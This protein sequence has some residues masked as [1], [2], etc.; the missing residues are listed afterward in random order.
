MTEITEAIVC[1]TAALPWTNVAS[2]APRDSTCWRAVLLILCAMLGLS[3]ARETQAQLIADLSLKNTVDVP[4]PGVGEQ[5]TFMVTIVNAGPRSARSIV[6]RDRLPTGYTYVAS[7]TTRGAYNATN[8]RWNLGLAAGE[9]AVLN[10]VGSVKAQGNY[11]DVAEVLASGSGDPDSMPGNGNSDEDD[12]AQASIAPR[13]AQAPNVIVV[14]V[15]DLD[16]RSLD[17]LL[18]AGLMPNFQTTFVERGIEFTE[19]FVSTPL[20]CPSRATFLKG[21]Y[22]HNTGIVNNQLLYPGAGL[23]W[24]VSRFDDSVTLATRLQGLGYRTAHIGK[25]LNGYGSDPRLS[26]L[27]PA[28][29]PH[30]I[31]PGWTDWWGLVDFSTYC[32]Y[33]YTINHNATLTQILRPLGETENSAAYQT[34]VLADTAEEF[35]LD[36]KD[37]A[38]PFYLQVMPLAPHNEQCADAYGGPPPGELEL[39]IRAAPEFANA[40]VPAFVPSAAYDEDLA[41]KP[42]WLSGVAPLTPSDYTNISEQYEARLRALLSV[43]VLIG[44]I[45]AALGSDSD[46]T[47]IVFTS[48]NGWLYGEHRRTAKVYAY[49]EAA[50]V[51]LYV[52]LPSSR[53]SG[54]RRNLVLNNDVAPTILDLASPGYASAAFDGRSLVPLLLSPAPAPWTD[55]VQFLIE[56]GRSSPAPGADLWPSYKAL[57]TASSLYVESWSDEYYT[58]SNSLIGLELYDLT[59][60]PNEMSSLLH[61]PENVQ[62]PVLA[63]WLSLLSTCKGDACMH[64]ENA[65]TAP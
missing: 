8:G 13:S 17:D 6:V 25:Y 59:R 50:A 18:A 28:F 23:Q 57:R 55:R 14:M 2:T 27:S 58:P 34:N 35:V 53:A 41:D 38:Q 24:A 43:D 7:Q 11:V 19:S 64:Y 1:P 52:V 62:D 42:A 20:C 54:I 9:T 12:Y 48:D 40:P 30:Y 65:E 49:R 21:Q 44:R 22:A 51:P 4:R 33:D 32:M 39:R 26:S 15:D 31:P 29:D 63:P 60:D 36:H 46:N 5:V 37:A 3:I 61:L 45:V 47:L 56:Y 10:L 16:T